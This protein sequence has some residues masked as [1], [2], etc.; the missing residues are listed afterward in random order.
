MNKK[1]EIE[2]TGTSKDDFLND[3]KKVCNPVKKVDR[4][5]STSSKT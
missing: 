2:K 3:L 5:N 4:P 1:I